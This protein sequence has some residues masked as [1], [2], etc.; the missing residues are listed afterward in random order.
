MNY[1][2]LSKYHYIYRLSFGA[3]RIAH[4][5]KLP[6]AYSNKHYIYVIEP[7][8]DELIKIILEPY[9]CYS[10][11]QFRTLEEKQKQYVINDI[12]DYFYHREHPNYAR[13]FFYIL[14]DPKPLFEFAKQL[15]IIDLR[16]EYL[17]NKK[18]RFE[19]KLKEYQEHI[20][21]YQTELN[22]INLELEKINS[23]LKKDGEKVN[24]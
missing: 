15:S 5:E 1:K 19:R 2:Y 21:S 8:S 11:S 9:D 17:L 24:D 3:D 7:G 20:N 23:E 10:P 6:I 16:K 22:L 4:V 12:I 13:E 18:N 14:D